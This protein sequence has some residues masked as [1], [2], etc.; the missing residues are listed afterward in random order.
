MVNGLDQNLL[1]LL[2][3]TRTPGGQQVAQQALQQQASQL[4]QQQGIQQAD[5]LGQAGFPVLGQLATAGVGVPEITKLLEQ[6]RIGENQ[7]ATRELI[8]QSLGGIQGQPDITD[9]QQQEARGRALLLSPQTAPLGQSI[10]RSV[11]SQKVEQRRVAAETRGVEISEK[12]I[13]KAAKIPGLELIPGQLPD[14]TSIR[15]ARKAETTRK[16]LNRT[17]DRLKGLIREAGGTE[18]LPTNTKR[19]LKQEIAGVRNTIRE[20]A[21]TG[22]LNIGEI[23]FLE[24]QFGS[25]DPTNPFNVTLSEDELISNLEQFRQGRNEDFSIQIQGLGFNVKEPIAVPEQ[26]PAAPANVIRFDAQGNRL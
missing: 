9:I 25:F 5:I 24:E 23:P 22:V 16:T 14:P 6:R 11:E 7:A 19:K 12:K 15:N 17:L 18:F 8:Q 2:A 21:G 20:L 4:A 26:Q 10:L 13:E 3:L 1:G